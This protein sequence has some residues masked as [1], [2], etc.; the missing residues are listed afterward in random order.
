MKR[1]RLVLTVTSILLLCAMTFS[2]V[3]CAVQSE[4]DTN[5]KAEV[6]KEQ[7][8]VTKKLSEG[9]RPNAVRIN[10]LSPVDNKKYADFAVRLF[11]ESEKSGENTLISPLS[12]IYALSMTANG[13]KGETLRQMEEVLGMS[14]DELNSYLFSYVRA[15][16]QG[17]SYKLTLANSV[18]FKDS[19]NF[20]VNE[21]F[22][23]TNADYYGADIFK[24]PF[25][26]ETLRDINSWVNENTDGMIPEILDEIPPMA[27]MYLV[28]ALTFEADWIDQYDK[29]SVRESTFTKEDGRS[30]TVEYMNGSEDCY[31]E[32][33]NAVGFMKY[34]KGKKY[35]FVAMLPDEGVS[36]SEYAASLDGEKLCNILKNKSEHKV[37][38]KI[39]K[40]TADYSVNLNTILS[41]MG[42]KDA[43]DGAKADFTG[44]GNSDDNNLFIR[45][46]LHKTHIE[47]GELGTKAGAATAVEIA[48]K[49][50]VSHTP[51]KAV[52][53]DRPFVYMLIDC[54]NNIPFFIGTMMDPTASAK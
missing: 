13:A 53:L 21:D 27:V 25:N 31:L 14:K 50:S 51:P 6:N 45:R 29:D 19:E 34:Y 26:E 16:P 10:D 47:V 39:P 12:V 33:E 9:I 48:L 52:Y 36:V 42:I 44:L 2:F 24:A 41:S 28:N 4:A 15:L 35:A 7:L 54:E 38:T 18:W 40:F 49:G 8:S 37:L 30:E 46:V 22:L 3:G 11:K 17:D 32:D 23:Q 5:E 1:N 43:F 20:K